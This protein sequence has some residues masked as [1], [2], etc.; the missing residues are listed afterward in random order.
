MA[1]E[2]VLDSYLPFASHRLVDRV[3]QCLLLTALA[4][5]HQVDSSHPI[6]YMLPLVHTTTSTRLG[7]LAAGVTALFFLTSAFRNSR[8]TLNSLQ[9]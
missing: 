7:L 6:N 8:G 9:T 5:G 3:I 2:C 1:K 4:R